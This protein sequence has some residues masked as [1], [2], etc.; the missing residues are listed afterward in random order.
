MSDLRKY[1][2]RY[3]PI[4]IREVRFNYFISTVFVIP[5]SFLRHFTVL[6]LIRH[7]PYG[8]VPQAKLSR[9]KIRLTAFD[10]KQLLQSER[11]A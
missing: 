8:I 11:K 9:C 10:C 2:M 5:L 1:N 6:Q 7:S 4:G 3:L